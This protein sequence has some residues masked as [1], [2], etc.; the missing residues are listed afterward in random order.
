[1]RLWRFLMRRGIPVVLKAVGAFLI[2]GVVLAGCGAGAVPQNFTTPVTSLSV[3]TTAVPPCPFR[4]RLPIPRPRRSL[5]P[6]AV[7]PLRLPL[8]W[9]HPRPPQRYAYRR[10]LRPPRPRLHPVAATTTATS[11]GTA[12]TGLW[13][14]PGRPQARR[15]VV[16]TAHTASAHTAK[17]PAPATAASR[18]GCSWPGS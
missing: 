2:G 15:P 17:A 13:R 16:M 1:V 5:P 4:R 7:P 3:T 9:P 18:P 11:T 8:R 14:H 10:P 6:A 12:Y